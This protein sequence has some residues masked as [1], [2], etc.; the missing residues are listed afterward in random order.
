MRLGP[1]VF[2]VSPVLQGSLEGRTLYLPETNGGKL[3]EKEGSRR[4]DAQLVQQKQCE[5]IVHLRS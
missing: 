2:F 4:E 5:K 1:A 3:D